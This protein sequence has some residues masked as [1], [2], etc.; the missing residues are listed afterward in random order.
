MISNSLRGN[1][2]YFIAMPRGLRAYVSKDFVILEK[3]FDNTY[4]NYVDNY[5]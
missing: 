1:F 2:I 5:N 3:H 4:Q